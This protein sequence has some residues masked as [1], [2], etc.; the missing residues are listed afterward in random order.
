MKTI[1][2]VLPHGPAARWRLNKGPDLWYEGTTAP[3]YGELQVESSLRNTQLEVYRDGFEPYGRS[4]L[5]GTDNQQIRVGVPADPARPQDLI[6][7]ALTP[8][9]SLPDLSIDGIRFGITLNGTDQFCALRDFAAGRDITPLIRESEAIGFNLWRVLFMGSAKQNGILQLDPRTVYDAM[10]PLADMLNRAGI[11]L[12]AVVN[13]DAQ[14]I[15]PTVTDRMANW[16]AIHGLLTG[17]ATLASYG[18]EWT[19]NGFDPTEAT[20]F[21]DWVWSRGSDVGDAMPYAPVGR[22]L[23]FHPRRDLPAALLDTVASPVF[24]YQ[25]RPHIPLIIDEPPRMG[26]DG[27]GPEYRDPELCYRFARHYSTECAGA[28]F[29]SRAGQISQ[30]MDDQTRACAD[31]WTRGM[32]R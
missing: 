3:D 9:F 16:H 26:S 25:N 8:T 4:I 2:L 20:E 1:A 27:S 17:T 24:I 22:Y 30:L 11:V 10:R 21:F 15:L 14:D 7:P 29:H 6:L 23:E 19:K 5:L 32:V 28:V 12:L 13:A 18:N 31:A